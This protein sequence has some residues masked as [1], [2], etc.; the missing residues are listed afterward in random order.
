MKKPRGSA[1]SVPSG[2][3]EI[4]RHT[5]LVLLTVAPPG[6]WFDG[7]SMNEQVIQAEAF[8]KMHLLGWTADGMANMWMIESF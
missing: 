2:S 7:P 5:P 3:G 1:G 4:G 6:F 8:N